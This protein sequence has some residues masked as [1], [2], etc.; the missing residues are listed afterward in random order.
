MLS[1]FPVNFPWWAPFSPVRDENG[2][3]RLLHLHA[4]NPDEDGKDV[5]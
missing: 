5:R 2:H 4:L 1:P 3:D